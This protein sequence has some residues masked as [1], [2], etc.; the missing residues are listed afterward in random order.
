VDRT[1]LLCFLLLADELEAE[2]CELIKDV[3]GYFTEDPNVN[4]QAE[5]IP[6]LSYGQA[7]EMADAGCELVQPKAI[8]VARA[9]GLRLLVRGMDDPTSASIVSG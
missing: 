2:Q 5:H 6:R 8:Q 9:A 3:C 1:L 4:R 7:L